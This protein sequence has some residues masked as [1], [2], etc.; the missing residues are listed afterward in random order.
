MTTQTFHSNPGADSAA[1]AVFANHE[2]AES[3]VK[4]LSR[5]GFDIKRISVVGRGFHTAE[6]ATGFYNAGDRIV[7]SARPILQNGQPTQLQ[8]HAVLNMN[9]ATAQPL[10]DLIAAK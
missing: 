4:E 2:A 7:D 10:R 6:R 8:V 5:S 9:P 3:A 1:V